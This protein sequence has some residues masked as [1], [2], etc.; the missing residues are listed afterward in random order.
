MSCNAMG[1]A[2]CAGL[3]SLAAK[4]TMYFD[5]RVGNTC[6]V[7]RFAGSL[8]VLRV[9]PI[10]ITNATAMYMIMLLVFACG[11]WAVLVLGST[12]LAQPDV[13]GE[14]ELAPEGRGTQEPIRATIKQSGRYVRMMLGAKKFDLRITES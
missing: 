4:R 12:L 3:W 2:P 6:Y 7:S 8:L 13:A 10:R 9:V 14:W 1:H 11:M 5:A